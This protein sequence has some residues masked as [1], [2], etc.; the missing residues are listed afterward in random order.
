MDESAQRELAAHADRYRRVNDGIHRSGDEIFLCE[1]LRMDCNE[2][3]QLEGDEYAAV[4]ATRGRFL[5]LPGH[6]LAEID[7]VVQRHARYVIVRRRSE[8]FTVRYGG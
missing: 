7:A 2:L 8:A 4:R 5:V 6:E 1:C 3:V